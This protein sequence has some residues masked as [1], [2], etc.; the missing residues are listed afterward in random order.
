MAKGKIYAYARVSTPR[1]RVEQ[2]VRNILL[3]YPTAEVHCEVGTG[4][5]FEGREELDRLLKIVKSGDT[6][7]FDSV[8]RMSRSEEEGASLYEEL[9]FKNVI[10]IFLKE[11]H[12]NSSVY[13]EAI[14]RQIA[15]QVSTGDDATDAFIAAILDALNKY[16]VS[17]ARQQIRLAFRQAEKEV[18][19]LRQR[20]REGLITAKLNGK[21]LG[22]RQGVRVE[23]KKSIQ[24]KAVI[25]RTNRDF[26]GSLNDRDTMALAQVSRNS[27]YKYKRELLEEEQLL[28]EKH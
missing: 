10:M 26:C 13:R 14:D 22:R 11:G 19:D 1:Q 9:F 16:A 5:K 6:I 28:V 17:L 20:T 25:K 8:S 27:F 23:T 24:A 3:A 18:A 7:V 4:T 2:Q 21:K 12:V 15:L